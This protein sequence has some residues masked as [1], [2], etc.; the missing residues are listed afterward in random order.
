MIKCRKCNKRMTF[1]GGYNQGIEKPDKVYTHEVY[2]CY[3]CN[4]RTVKKN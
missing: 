4:T 1:A 2:R 3:T